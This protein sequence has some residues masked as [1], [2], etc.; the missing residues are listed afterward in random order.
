MAHAAKEVLTRMPFATKMSPNLKVASKKAVR[1]YRD[2]LRSIP[3]ALKIYQ[4]DLTPSQMK[5]RIRQEFENKR[6]LQDPKVIDMLVFKA[7]LELDEAKKGWKTKSHMTRL[8]TP[9]EEPSEK[10]EE[11][12]PEDEYRRNFLARY[13]P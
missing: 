1:L 9:I 3:A 10:E 6:H 2:L 5:R 7:Y 12:D 11:V 8:L 13:E 4:L